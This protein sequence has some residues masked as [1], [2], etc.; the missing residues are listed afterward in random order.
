MNQVGEAFA[1][2][3]DEMITQIID[4]LTAFLSSEENRKGPDGDLLPRCR[5]AGRELSPDR[6]S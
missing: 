4:H 3:D 2:E 6:I 1:I 5:S